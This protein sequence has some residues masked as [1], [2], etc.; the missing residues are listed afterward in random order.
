MPRGGVSASVRLRVARS[1]GL[2]GAIHGANS[3]AARQ[4]AS[5]SAE[6][7]ATGGRRES[8]VVGKQEPLDPRFRG[9]DAAVSNRA[10]AAPCALG[11][12]L[13]LLARVVHKIAPRVGRSVD[14][15]RAIP[16]LRTGPLAAGSRRYLIT[17]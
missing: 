5:T 13:G 16:V 17:T 6:T 14:S 1:N 11:Q 15:P 2:C 10:A 4:T 8:S 12:L 9:D 7:S 3:A